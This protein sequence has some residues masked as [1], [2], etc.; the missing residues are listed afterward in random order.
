[1]TVPKSNPTPTH[2]WKQTLFSLGAI[3]AL[4]GGLS[5][6]AGGAWLGIQLIVNPDAI[7][8]LPHILPEWTEIPVD[9]ASAPK[10]LDKIQNDILQQGLMAGKAMS[11]PSNRGTATDPD[12]LLPVIARRSACSVS[13]DRIIELRVYQ[14]VAEEFRP[15]SDRSYYYLANRIPVTGP[16]ESFVIAPLFN[17]NSTS[18][19]STRPLPLTAVK[20]FNQSTP[21]PGLWFNL[22]GDRMEGDARVAYGQVYH[23]NPNRSHLSLMVQWTSTVGKSPTWEQ[24]TGGATAELQIDRTVGLEPHFEVYQVQPRN[25]LLNPIQLTSISIAEPAIDGRTYKNALLLARNGLWSPAL[26]ILE[27]LKRENESNWTPQAQAQLD[28]IALHARMTRSNADSSWS[29]PS[30]AAL[31]TLIDGRWEAALQLFEENPANRPAI[32]TMLSSDT[33]RLW[34]RV[35]AELRVNLYNDAAKAWGALL[36]S[37][38]QDRVKA[39]E[40]VQEQPNNSSW[41]NQRI[42]KLLAQL[43]AAR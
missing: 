27:T 14:T 23:Y 12:V 8:W 9:N 40:W 4:A 38:Q 15:T 11:L 29:N 19:G 32:A 39:M 13:C 22:I 41:A 25:F 28:F 37:A 1:M 2:R 17:T 36:I 24:F 20:A 33:G 43:E 3:A 5:L 18:P 7:L 30:Q 21:A 34:N 31:A 26:E 16:A 35:D 10:T 42:M 6:V